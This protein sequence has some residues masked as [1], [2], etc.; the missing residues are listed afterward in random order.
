[1]GS[2]SSR[3]IESGLISDQDVEPEHPVQ[4]VT[5]AANS[6]MGERS[7]FNHFMEANSCMLKMAKEKYDRYDELCKRYSEIQKR[8]EQLTAENGS[9]RQ[10]INNDSVM[11]HRSHQSSSEDASSRNKRS[12][13]LQKYK[14]MDGATRRQAM[15]AFGKQ[16]R[17]AEL[18]YRK[19]LTCRI[20][21]IAYEFAERAKDTFNEQALPRLFQCAP[22]VGVLFE[23][24]SS[25]ATKFSERPILE[26]MRSVLLSSESFKVAC[27]SVLK[28]MAVSCD[29][30]DLEENVMRELKIR[31]EQWRDLDPWL[32]YLDDNIL[33]NSR[34]K[35]YIADCLRLAWRMVNLL[36]P[37]KIKKVDD[38]RDNELNN[39]FEKET[40]ENK[41]KVQTMKVCVWPAVT[42]CDN[43]NEVLVKGTVVIIP[44]PKNQSVCSV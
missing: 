15:E 30:T 35:N 34:V 1:M 14:T 23:N 4:T 42:D 32:P 13:V 31:S 6:T 26:E 33:G 28:E 18:W 38:V 27:A 11:S 2:C 24:N 21:L 8:N 10:R 5:Q 39:F 12:D 20:F 36:P 43:P 22:S 17:R 25:Q 41:E 44:R 7:D 37:L 9:L 19:D 29:L 40:E 16:S 3:S